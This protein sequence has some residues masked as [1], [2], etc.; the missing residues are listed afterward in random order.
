MAQRIAILLTTLALTACM[1]PASGPPRAVSQ[2][3]DPALD[4]RDYLLSESDF[5]TIITAARQRVAQKA[6][7]LAVHRVHVASADKVTAYVGQPEDWLAYIDFQRVHGAWRI[8]DES[9][10]TREIVI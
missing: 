8:I 9:Y 4:G 3:G 10:A 2:F 7:W 6:P 5:R 1:T